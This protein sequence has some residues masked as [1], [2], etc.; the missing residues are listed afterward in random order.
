MGF[1]GVCPE[2]FEDILSPALAPP[3]LRFYLFLAYFRLILSS[4]IP[5]VFRCK[6]DRRSTFL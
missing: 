3:H 2:S 4:P 1:L 5:F 6:D